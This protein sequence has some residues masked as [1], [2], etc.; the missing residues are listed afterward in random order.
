MQYDS[1]N[2]P[3]AVKD[4][5]E[6]IFGNE[7]LC[8]AFYDCDIEIYDGEWVK[9]I[10]EDEAWLEDLM[11]PGESTYEDLK[12]FARDGTGALWVVIND[13]LIG[14]I[15]TEGECGIVAKNINEFFNIVAVYRGCLADIWSV[16]VLESEEAFLEAAGEPEEN[17]VFDD[18]IKKHGFTKDLKDVYK[19]I[20]SGMTTEPFFIHKATDDDYVDSY[21]LVGSD[22]GQEALEDLI[23]RLSK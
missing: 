10:E 4:F 12:P 7:E 22:D 8:D 17:E 18:F 23:S 6:E 11:G 16:D 20:I 3:Q 21:S 2:L 9:D 14:Y 15:G 13:E 5:L 19:M 1:T